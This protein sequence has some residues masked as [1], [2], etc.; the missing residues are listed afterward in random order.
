M[1]G[2][3]FFGIGPK[4][5]MRQYARLTGTSSMPQ[6][7]ASAYHQCCWNYRDKEDLANL[8]GKFDEFDIPYDVLWL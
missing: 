8:E 5:V 2:F 7:F 1:D 4:D 3:L 6:L